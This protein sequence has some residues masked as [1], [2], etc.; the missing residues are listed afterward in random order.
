MGLETTLAEVVAEPPAPP[1][2]RAPGGLTERELEVARL[3]AEGRTN[4]EIAAEL[5][6][7][8]RTVARHLEH[9]LAKLN[10]PSR[11][12]AAAVILRA[13]LA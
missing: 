3:V 10:T 1:A 5:I 8:E 11:T 6:V 12:A 2:P 13:G 7:S 4:R 9:I